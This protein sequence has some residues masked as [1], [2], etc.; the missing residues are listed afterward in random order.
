MKSAFDPLRHK[1]PNLD[2]FGF[3]E[4]PMNPRNMLQRASKNILADTVNIPKWWQE[5]RIAGSQRQSHE[6]SK[7]TRATPEASTRLP[8]DSRSKSFNTCL[9]TVPEKMT[10]TRLI[11]NRKREALPDLSYDIDGDGFVGGRDY[12]VARRFDQGQK[13]FLTDEEREVL[14]E[15][16]ANVSNIIGNSSN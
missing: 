2:R 15:Q 7:T 11:E 5:K 10:R 1:V 14:F 6:L 9:A 3:N 13:N 16:L 4:D 8:I 12:V